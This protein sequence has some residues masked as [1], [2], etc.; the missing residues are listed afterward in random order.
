[1]E[2]KIVFP[3]SNEDFYQLGTDYK[4]RTEFYTDLLS[5]KRCVLRDEDVPE[6]LW[7]RIKRIR[8]AYE[9]RDA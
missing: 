3:M 5:A 8:E 4:E 6:E 7:S 9:R 1:M 2:E